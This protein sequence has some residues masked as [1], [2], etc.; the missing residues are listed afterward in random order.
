[1]RNV[2][3]GAPGDLYCHVVLETPVKLSDKQRKL[4]QEFEAALEEGGERHSPQSKGWM[5]K[6]KDFFN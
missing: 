4:L 1:V 6:V 5:D 2:R 3:S